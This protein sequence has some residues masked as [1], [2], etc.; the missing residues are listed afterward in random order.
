[1][2]DAA[3]TL[4]AAPAKAAP[5]A[6]L[7]PAHA[8][9][10][11]LVD[12]EARPLRAHPIAPPPEGERARRDAAFAAPG[13]K[14]S[15]HH[16]P[17]R[18]ESPSPLGYRTRLPLSR[19][20]AQAALSLL[21]LAPPSG[22]LPP[23]E[24]GEAGRVAERALFEECALGVLSSRQSTNF[25]GHR[26]VILGPEKA[27][28]LGRLLER[29]AGR[30][31]PVLGHATHAHVVLSRA[32]RTPFTLLL[33]FLG[34]RPG[35]S[36]ATVPLRALGKLLLDR[37]D[38]PT[39]DA[40]R[41]LHLGLLQ[42]AVERA[43]ILA[44][45][46]ARRALVHAAPFC[47]EE[48]RRENAEVIAAIEALAGIGAAERRRGWRVAFVAQVGAALPG[49][50]APLPPALCRRLGANLLA[51]RSERAHP[52]HNADEKAPPQYRRPQTLGVPPAL[53]AEAT[54]AALNGFARWSGLPRERAKR[55]LLLEAID[56]RAEAGALRLD[57]VRAMLDRVSERAMRD[58]P[59]WCDLPT[60]YLLSRNAAR[61]KKAFALAGDRVV[62]G[63]LSPREVR[64][65]GLPFERAVRAA[66]A[67]AGRA[68][69]LCEIAGV[70]GLPAGCDLLG[71]VCV[72]AGPVNQNDIG[73]TFYGDPDL[74]AKTFPGRDPMSLLVF[75]FKA[76]T[77]A[78]PIGNEEQLLNPAKKGALVDLR[79]GPHEVI[80]VEGRDGRFA[81]MRSSAGRVNEERAFADQGNF[82]T[83]PDGAEVPGNRGAPWPGSDSP[84]W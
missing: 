19:E 81:P 22:F 40:L 49:E 50:R 27:A 58:I 15:R 78:D 42:D 20:E 84:L 11:P 56:P 28:A 14:R 30:E 52:G 25:R 64:E 70:T 23:A 76:K 46:G 2:S 68:S 9:P 73:K 29:A 79:P 17:A 31:A 10:S 74:L 18:L 66:G 4:A 63:G 72:M 32:Y 7:A 67:A 69:L 8:R 5:M 53:Y 34:H 57:E 44:S 43:A 41:D 60:G 80:T 35:L 16:L 55:L 12:R 48:R 47:G 59:L 45:G 38:I 77:V 75:T 6:A 24:A 61:G 36:L 21:S 3:A 82:V 37:V 33:T 51:F 54:R 13:E 39:I 71:G 65:A 62:L 26:A 1:M 83:A